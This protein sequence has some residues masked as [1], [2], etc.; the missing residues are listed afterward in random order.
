YKI[1]KMTENSNEDSKLDSPQ[2]PLP[3]GP[4]GLP[5]IGSILDYKG[6]KTNLAWT[7]QFGPIYYVKM[8]SKNLL[9]LNT[10]ELVQKY[11]EGKKGELFLDRPMG[12]GAIAE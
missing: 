10:L 5:C 9:Y 4:S 7:K 6:P 12:P 11:L 8:G 1:A 2:K 3:P